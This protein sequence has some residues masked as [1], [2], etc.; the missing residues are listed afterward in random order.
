MA[1]VPA[2]DQF[3]DKANLSVCICAVVPGQGSEDTRVQE[4]A[5]VREASDAPRECMEA[6]R[7]MLLE[8]A[9]RACPTEDGVSDGQEEASA[10]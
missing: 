2:L 5:D 7:W 6:A 10:V 4:E 9:R 3:P 8:A 1:T